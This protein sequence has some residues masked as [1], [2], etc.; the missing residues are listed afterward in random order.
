VTDAERPL[1]SQLA[2]VYSQ[3]P[4]SGRQAPQLG[5]RPVHG[6]GIVQVYLGYGRGKGG[7]SRRGEKAH[8]KEKKSVKS[9]HAG[10]KSK[11]GR[12]SPKCTRCTGATPESKIT[13]DP[14]PVRPYKPLIFKSVICVSCS[15][16]MR[17]GPVLRSPDF[18]GGVALP[19]S[20]RYW[21]RT[22]STGF[23][24]PSNAAK[25][26]EVLR[27]DGYGLMPTVHPARHG[28]GVGIGNEV[29][30]NLLVARCLFDTI[31]Y[32]SILLA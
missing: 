5:A 26:S 22:G 31:E 20:G 32:P 12:L 8:R 16:L 10:A 14:F 30:E 11:T 28:R 15:V 25:G 2:A 23:F 1:T 19:W 17:G 27:L 6:L 7:H 24:Q 3:R 4:V 29:V 18:Q 21:N 13:L 9:Q